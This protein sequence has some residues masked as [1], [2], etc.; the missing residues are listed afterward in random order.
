MDLHLIRTE[1]F[2]M[3]VLILQQVNNAK[4]GTYR[5]QLNIFIQANLKDTQSGKNIKNSV[6]YTK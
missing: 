2:Q 5:L 1:R 4:N 3:G 6:R